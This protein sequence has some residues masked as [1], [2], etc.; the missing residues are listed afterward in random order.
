MSSPRRVGE[1]VLG[2]SV[3]SEGLL[4]RDVVLRFPSVA[5]VD[6]MLTAFPDLEIPLL[7]GE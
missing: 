2:V 4:A 7:P 5:D 6:A 1:P 3:A